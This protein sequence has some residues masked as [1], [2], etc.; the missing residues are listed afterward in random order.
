MSTP[1]NVLSTGVY[2]GHSVM[3]PLKILIETLVNSQTKITF[4]QLWES[5]KGRLVRL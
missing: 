5:E 1:T 3:T 4:S 2:W